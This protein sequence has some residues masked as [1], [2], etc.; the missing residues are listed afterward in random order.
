MWISLKIACA[1]RVS[2][3]GERSAS[4]FTMRY[5]TLRHCKLYFGR[6]GQFLGKDW[7]KRVTQGGEAAWWRESKAERRGKGK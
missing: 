7:L 2:R 4:M 1:E 5:H 3:C 6:A